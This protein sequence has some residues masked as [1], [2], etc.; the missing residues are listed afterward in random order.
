[1]RTRISIT[2]VLAAVVLCP[3]WTVAQST[4]AGPALGVARISV[5][6]GDVA[7]MRGD[8]GDWVA[9]TVNM[10]VVEGDSVQSGIGSKVEI[11]LDHGNFVRLWHD[12]EVQLL[13]LA[14][15]RFR[16]RVIQGAVIYSELPGSVADIDVETPFAA[17]RPMKTGRYRVVVEPDSALLAVRQGRAEI[18]FQ[19]TAS[20]LQSGHSMTVNETSAGS[21]TETRKGAPADAFDRWAV[22]RDKYLRRSRPYRYLSRDIYGADMLDDHGEWRYVSGVGYSWFPYV[23][24]AWVPYRQGRWIW[25]DYYGWTWVGSEPW[26]WAPYHWGRW[27]RHT[28]YGWGWYPGAPRLRHTW[29]PALVA[30]FAY[31]AIIR[32]TV[33][34]GF[35]GIG[36]CPL[37]PGEAFVPWYGRRHYAGASGNTILVDNSVN[38]FNRYQNARGYR[39]VSSVNARDFGRGGRHT[40]RSMRTS[41]VRQAVAIRGPVP[42]VPERSSQ[43]RLVRASSSGVDSALRGLRRDRPGTLRDGTA[44]VSFESQQERLRSSIDTFRT[45]YRTSVNRAASPG[46]VRA[47][48]GGQSGRLVSPAAS[49]ASQPGSQRSPAG[50]VAG[51]ATRSPSSSTIRRQRSDSGRN[52]SAVS[53]GTRPTGTSVRP[54]ASTAVNPPRAAPRAGTRSPTSVFAPRSRSRTG[55]L[56]TSGGVARTTRRPASA[57]P[58]TGVRVPASSSRARPAPGTATRA[59]APNGRVRATTVGGGSGTVRGRASPPYG[60]SQAQGRSQTIPPRSR[61]TVGAPPPVFAPRSGSRVSGASRTRASESGTVRNPTVSPSRGSRVGSASSARRPSSVSGPRTYGTGRTVT[62]GSGSPSVGSYGSPST[63]RPSYAPRPVPQSRP[64]TSRSTS[65]TVRPS[66]VPSRSGSGSASRSP[67]GGSA[68]RSPSRLGSMS[69]GRVGRSAPAARAPSGARPSYGGS[70]PSSSGPYRGGYGGSS[71]GAA[72]SVPRS[73]ASASRSASGT[74][75]RSSGSRS[76]GSRSSASSGTRRDR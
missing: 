6:S 53:S 34:G 71:A 67:V 25:V 50:A 69:T 14:S 20:E 73:S 27:Y 4:H 44:R 30:F 7:T 21:V 64:S 46:T 48:V 76:S 66:R 52:P 28:R 13:E 62:P 47:A 61:A 32:S 74:S 11:Q 49:R 42:V 36:W 57:H 24:T 29:R 22:D 2:A 68:S 5:V 72:R 1:M 45:T 55:A 51:S 9:A 60:T 15:K 40:P 31:D 43:G 23:T 39:G 65:R 3:A 26:G 33:W 58:P 56:S 38:I 12:S 41:T 16:I 35:A 18:A 70:R 37:A 8:S 75:S 54:A 19:A 10:P 17:V 59:N 63:G